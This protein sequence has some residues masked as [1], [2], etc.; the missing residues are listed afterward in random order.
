MKPD[1]YISPLIERGG[2]FSYRTFSVGEG[3]RTSFR[4][5]LIE[6]A[7]HDRRAMIAEISKDPCREVRS[8][9]TMAEFERLTTAARKG[10]GAGNDQ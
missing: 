7:R 8:C 5:P 1:L 6:Q 9:E 3:T 2:K 10:E 4:Y